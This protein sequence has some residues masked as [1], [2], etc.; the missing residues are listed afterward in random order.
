MGVE[1]SR[2]A[3]LPDEIDKPEIRKMIIESWTSEN[4]QGS[5]LNSS[6]S[7]RCESTLGPGT[8]SKA[9]KLTA[10]Y[11]SL[12][13]KNKKNLKILEVMAGNC[14]ASKIMC[15]SLSPYIDMSN[16]ISTDMITCPTR[17]KSIPFVPCNPVEA[18]QKFGPMSDLLLMI[19]PSPY[20][21]Y[22]ENSENKDLGYGDYYAVHD[23]I[24]QAEHKECKHIIIIG[25]LGAS[26]G[27][28]GMYKYILNHENLKLVVR[29]ILYTGKDIF[30][31]M[32]EKE[33]FIFLITK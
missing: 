23:Y 7:T 2:S 25:E 21:V 20:P 26:D 15:D 14:V 11:F 10:E 17:I 6:Q 18:V 33:L 32:V 5:V 22:K 3:C 4:I 24:A 13:D 28:E 9:G 30:G 19:S 31:G 1:M 12:H 27:S 29:E 16:W 8:L